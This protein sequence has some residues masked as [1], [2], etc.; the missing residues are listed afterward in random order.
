MDAQDTDDQQ[1]AR[2]GDGPFGR[3]GHG[4]LIIQAKTVAGKRQLSIRQAA[5]GQIDAHLLGDNFFLHSSRRF[6]LHQLQGVL[7]L[8][9]APARSPSIWCRRERITS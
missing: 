9:A 2:V 7:I 8:S 4:R 6:C 1:A 3:E 5:L